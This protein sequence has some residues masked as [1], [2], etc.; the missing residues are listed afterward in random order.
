[1]EVTVI[2][3]FNDLENKGEVREVGKTFEVSEERGMFLIQEGYVIK[4][5]KKVEVK[6]EVKKAK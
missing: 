2:E 6:E 3:R 4:A 1:M 5:G